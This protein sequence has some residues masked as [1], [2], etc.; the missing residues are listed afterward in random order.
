MANLPTRQYRWISKDF[1]FVRQLKRAYA[2]KAAIAS[3]LIILAVA[4]GIALFKST[5]AGGE[6][7][8]TDAGECTIL[9]LS[10]QRR[11]GMDHRI[12]IHLLPSNILL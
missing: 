12:W 7:V 1:V 10:P 11:F 4:F 8:S 2:A 5:N 6:V 9:T 3:I